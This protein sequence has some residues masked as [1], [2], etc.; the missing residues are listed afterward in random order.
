MT[1]TRHVLRAM[2]PFVL[3]KATTGRSEV[4]LTFD[5][6]PDPSTTPDILD[7]LGDVKA[8][9]FMLGKQV[10]AHPDMAR[11]V[12][13]AGHE[14][15]SHGDT[16]RRATRMTPSATKA[17]LSLGW[18]TIVDAT[19][20]LPRF[21]RPPHGVFSPSAWQQAARL[22]MRRTLW[23][24][25]AKDWEAGATAEG[26]TACVLDAVMPGDVVLMHDAGGWPGRARVTAA[27][28]PSLLRGLTE[29]DLRPVTLSAL[30]Q[31]EGRVRH[32]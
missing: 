10:R 14:V 3:S 19:G 22:Q 27:A 15:A 31:D 12:V 28:I 18:A 5:D 26:V 21:Y 29:R 16:H 20:R 2:A 30:T 8:T 17:D 24:C 7:A 11:M 13:E 32:G 4:A 9:F 1:T 23:S 6:G 25:S